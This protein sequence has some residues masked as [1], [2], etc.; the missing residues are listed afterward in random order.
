MRESQY[1]EQY[2]DYTADR[3]ITPGT[4]LAYMLRGKAKDYTS[5]Y[6]KALQRALDRRQEAGTVLC[7]RSVGGRIAYIRRTDMRTE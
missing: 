3:P 1:I 4:Y 7:V 6:L 2:L 5:R